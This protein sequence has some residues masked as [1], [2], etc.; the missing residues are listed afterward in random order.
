MF[1]FEEDFY[2]FVKAQ[3]ERKRGNRQPISDDS[4]DEEEV[5]KSTI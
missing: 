5:I 2:K 3:L 4:D 1:D